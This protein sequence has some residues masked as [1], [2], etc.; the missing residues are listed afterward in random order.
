MYVSNTVSVLVV[1]PVIIKGTMM[2]TRIISPGLLS[3][4]LF[5][6]KL[7]LDLAKNY[8]I[9]SNGNGEE[10]QHCPTPPKH[11]KEELRDSN[12]QT[13]HHCKISGHLA[14]F[15]GSHHRSI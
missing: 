2:T 13:N 9:V 1:R 10:V 15:V 3:S 6:A 11:A 4:Y 12:D 5:L 7:G 14:N 8:S